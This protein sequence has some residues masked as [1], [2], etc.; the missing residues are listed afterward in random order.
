M[1]IY[2]DDAPNLVVKHVV[3]MLPTSASNGVVAYLGRA[4]DV[5]K[6]VAALLRYFDRQQVIAK[7]APNMFEVLSFG[8]FA[9]ADQKE[10]LSRS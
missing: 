6:R 3:I 4:L 5:L 10:S 7:S 2:V 8:D 1:L 9:L